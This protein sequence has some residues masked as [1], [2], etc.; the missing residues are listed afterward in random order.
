MVTRVIAWGFRSLYST[1]R[2]HVMEA[3]PGIS[4]YAPANEPYIYCVWHDGISNA[5]FCGRTLA[6]AALTSRH[7]D[8]EYVAEIMRVVGI[9]PVRGSNNHGGATAVKQMMESARDK[10]VVITT[11]GP[12]GPR[13]VI[14]PGILFLASQS[15]RAILPVGCSASRAWF[16]KGKWTDLLVPKPF[17]TAYVLGAKPFIVPQGLAKDELEPYKLQLQRIMDRTQ[18]L[19]D[20]VARGELSMEEAKRL[21]ASDDIGQ[22]VADN[23]KLAA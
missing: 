13:R 21:S 4:P 20:Q 23:G 7:A 10:H 9:H 16:P 1:C 14:K 15:G 3:V 2:V 11:D 6:C 18:E 17:S 19:C 8:G 22:N 12:R 5:L